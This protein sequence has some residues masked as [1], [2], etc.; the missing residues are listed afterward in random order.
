MRATVITCCGLLASCATRPPPTPPAPVAAPSPEV[1]FYP[2]RGQQVGQ[3]DRDRYECYLWAR[4][5]SGF[6]PSRARPDQP[7][8]KVVPVP[9][10]GY[11][12]AVG[13]V[14]GAAIGA[15]IGQPNDTGQGAAIGAMA[16]AVLG[17]A[18]DAQRQQQA[19]ELQAQ[20]DAARNAASAQT[21]AAIGSYR[22][23]MQACLEARGYAVR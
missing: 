20:Q 1:F 21:D 7:L 18:S 9:P 5:R 17:A 11:G 3:Q 15:A 22:R 10:P 14:S 13:A 2:L 19:D 16:G 4:Q 12:A 6:D 23:A 8:V